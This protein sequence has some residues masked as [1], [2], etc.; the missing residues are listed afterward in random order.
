MT[1]LGPFLLALFYGG[2]MWVAVQKQDDNGS[3]NKIILVKQ[4]HSAFDSLPEMPSFTFVPTRIHRD[5][6]LQQVRNKQVQGLLVLNDQD[7]SQVDSAELWTQGGLSLLQEKILR[8]Q[9]EESVYRY[10]LGLIGLSSAEINSMRSPVQLQSKNISESITEASEATESGTELKS[11]VGFVM[12]FLI[13]LFIFLY[14]S[15][16]MR[17][18]LEEKT[19]RIVEVIISSVKPFELMMGK[20]L[21]VAAVGLTQFVAWVL[22]GFGIITAISRF[23]GDALSKGAAAASELKGSN[24]ASSEALSTGLDLWGQLDALPMGKMALVFLIFF[25]GGYLLYSSLFAAIGAAASQDTDVQSFMLPVSLPLIFGLI[26]AQ[27]SVFQSPNGSMATWFSQ[28]PLTSPIVMVVRSP[29]GVSWGEIAL[30]ALL[31]YTS[32]LGIVWVAG[33]IYRVGLLNY[34][35]KPSWKD[36]FSWIRQTR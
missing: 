21:G 25:L 36:L 4:S 13:Y 20:I 33:R 7:L 12:A 27:N 34:G 19:N 14:G 8:Q 29:F 5:S 2:I 10:Q 28:F 1:L 26:I 30:S 23:F 24:V 31:L 18:A 6:A 15:M 16:V 9:L 32:F 11:V 17:G 22:M 3:G 35:K